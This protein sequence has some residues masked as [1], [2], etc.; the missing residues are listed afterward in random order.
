MKRFIALLVCAI[1]IAVTFASCSDKTLLDGKPIVT[2]Q[3]DGRILYQHPV[4]IQFVYPSKWYVSVV[5][6]ENYINVS[7]IDETEPEDYV[8]VN[9][10]LETKNTNIASKM[11]EDLDH[12][13]TKSNDFNLLYS[14]MDNNDIRGDYGISTYTCT[15][16]NRPIRTSSIYM[17]IKDDLIIVIT[18]SASI[19]NYDQYKDDLEL[20][21]NSTAL[22]KPE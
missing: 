2:A 16:E 6:K 9:F 8:G 12:V 13:Q 17:N 3:D 14:A 4:G 1:F 21:V 22:Y 11:A 15:L 19:E 18:M 5:K 10:A 7:P 20:T